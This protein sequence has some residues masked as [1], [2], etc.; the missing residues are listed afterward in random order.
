MG[1]RGRG[2]EEGGVKKRGRDE[3]GQTRGRDFNLQ[4]SLLAINK[5]T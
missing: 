2:Q 4:F 1:G 5:Y 3:K